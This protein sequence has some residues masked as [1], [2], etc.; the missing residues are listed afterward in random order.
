[1][2]KSVRAITSSVWSIQT[3]EFS[4]LSHRPVSKRGTMAKVGQDAT[5][6]ISSHILRFKGRK[7]LV[8]MFAWGITRPSVEAATGS[9]CIRLMTIRRPLFPEERERRADQGQKC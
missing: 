8:R 9:V 2:R 4:T 6:V 1:M 5:A 7:M 3:S